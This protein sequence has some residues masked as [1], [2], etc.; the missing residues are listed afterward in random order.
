M[1]LGGHLNRSRLPLERFTSHAVGVKL[2]RQL[3]NMNCKPRTSQE[4]A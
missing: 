1:I 4:Q 2:Q 3:A